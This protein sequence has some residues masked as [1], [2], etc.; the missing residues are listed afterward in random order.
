MKTNTQKSLNLQRTRN[1]SALNQYQSVDSPYSSII[2]FMR[3]AL[4]TALA[5]G[6]ISNPY[7]AH[8]ETNAVTPSAIAACDV[9]T[10]STSYANGIFTSVVKN[11]GT[12]ATPTGVTVGVK[13]SMD[14][15]GKTWGSVAGPLAAGASVTIGTKGGAYVIP[16][17]TH[18]ITTFADDIDR[19]A[20]SNE[21]N[22]K[23][24]LVLNIGDLPDTTPPSIPTSILASVISSTQI[25]LSW[26]LSTD[27]VGVI[28]YK[29][30]RDGVQI[31]STSGTVGAD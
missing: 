2:G 16:T 20:E 1:S 11:Q 26:G 9:I 14:N 18:T 8:A 27:N 22:N 25:N 30:F 7:F 29:V 19:F 6:L 15:V 10:T 24:S 5:L 12:A 23:F 21:T 13:Y 31:A 4:L 3:I 17:G 28:G